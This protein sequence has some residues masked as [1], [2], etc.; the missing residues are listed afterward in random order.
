MSE[1]HRVAWV[2]SGEDFSEVQFFT[3]SESVALRETGYKLCRREKYDQYA[4]AGVVPHD[5][6]LD[7]GW[8]FTCDECERTYYRDVY[9]D[10]YGD[11]HDRDR[12]TPQGYC[13][14]EC[15]AEHLI[16]WERI[17]AERAAGE[18]R[19]KQLAP[20]A[21]VNRWSTGGVNCCGC[22]DGDRENQYAAITFPGCK[23]GN[24]HYCH[25]CG[26]IWI[27]PSDRAAW[28]A[29]KASVKGGVS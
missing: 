6:L 19:L 28:D 23:R 18:E 13:S 29:A 21:S 2:V 12:A 14:M 9:E 7:D 27:M 10:D 20:W 8:H 11:E 25:G 16:R 17:R 26:R 15:Y 22:Y 24:A 3:A 4:E 1:Q 5:V